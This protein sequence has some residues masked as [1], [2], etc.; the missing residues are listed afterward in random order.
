MPIQTTA[1][2]ATAAVRPPVAPIETGSMNQWTASAPMMSKAPAVAP[3]LNEDV[4]FMN[5][6]EQIGRQRQ[7]IV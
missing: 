7:A 4:A 6:P 3:R 2:I 1:L 5:A